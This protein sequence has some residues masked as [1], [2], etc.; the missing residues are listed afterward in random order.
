MTFGVTGVNALPLG[1]NPFVAPPGVVSGLCPDC[2][3][4]PRTTLVLDDCPDAPGS[5]ADW[6]LIARKIFSF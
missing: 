5:T 4:A 2:S 1:E 3:R 6:L